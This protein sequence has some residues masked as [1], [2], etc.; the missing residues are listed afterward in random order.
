MYITN[1]EASLYLCRLAL[2]VCLMIDA[3]LQRGHI[4]HSLEL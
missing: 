1:Y 2:R 4:V 3:M